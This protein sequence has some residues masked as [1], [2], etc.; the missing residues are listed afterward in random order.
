MFDRPLPDPAELGQLDD[1]AVIAAIEDCARAEAAAAARRL[2]AI[3]ELTRRRTASEEHANWACDEWDC[4]AAEVAAA[5]GVT[6]RRASGQMHLSLSLKRLPNVAALF[7]AGQIGERLMSAI[8]WRSFLVRDLEALKRIDADIAKMAAT[9]G[10]L[11]VAKLEQA[12][13]NSIDKHDPG[14]LRHTRAR[15]RSRD[16]CIGERNDEADTTALWGRLYATDAAALDER[17]NKM[18][19]GVCDGDSRTLAQ[20]RADALGALAAGAQHLACDCGS[21]ECAANRGED[22]RAS[23]VVVHVVAE[24]STLEAVPDRHMSGEGPPSRPITPEMT[25]AEA[26]AP[27]PQPDVPARRSAPALITSGGLVPAPL[28]AELIRGGAKVSRVRPAGNFVAEPHYRPSAKLA[29]F[30]RVRDLTCRFPGCDVPA[31]RCDID[32]TAPWP[33]GPTHPSNLKCACRKHHLLKTF[34][35]GWNDAQRPD[36][37]VIWTAPN[38]RTYTTHP[39]SRIFFPR[40]NTTTTELPEIVVP[41]DDFDDRGVMMPKRRHTRAAERAQR[42][43][44][45]RSL[46]DAHVAERNKPPPF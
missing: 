14:A 27:D 3:A 4:A 21:A 25:L 1:A 7:L 44:Y 23:A 15:A 37:T 22:Q 45:E 30:V 39:G 28:L 24:E 41:T 18:A 35:T 17:L 26:L 13:D 9:W 5:L 33:F 12:I 6:H 10:P 20:R 43:N 46:N 32:H 19:H 36:G 2:S 40:W 8:A 38:G 31:A 42:I 16:L 29:E 34:W 11:S